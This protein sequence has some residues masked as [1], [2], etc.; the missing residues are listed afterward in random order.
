MDQ[1]SPRRRIFPLKNSK[2]RS[3][4]LTGCRGVVEEKETRA[5]ETMCI[6]G[7]QPWALTASWATTYAAILTIVSIVVAVVCKASFLPQT[8]IRYTRGCVT[9]PKSP[10]DSFSKPRVAY[11]LRSI[12]INWIATSKSWFCVGIALWMRL[13]T[14]LSCNLY[15]FPAVPAHWL[16]TP[17]CVH[18]GL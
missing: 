14:R 13:N 2:F 5:R 3:P 16:V 6:M 15:G 1:H 17:F 8:D 9:V 4:H 18:R 10:A 7:L 11:K 12:S